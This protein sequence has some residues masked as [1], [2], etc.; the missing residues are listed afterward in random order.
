MDTS[1]RISNM[2]DIPD[3][4]HTLIHQNQWKTKWREV[5]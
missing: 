4:I 2:E 1:V 3:L 5:P